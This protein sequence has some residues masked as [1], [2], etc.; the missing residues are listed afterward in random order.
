VHNFSN[1][2]YR[3]LARGVA[4]VLASSEIVR[5]VYARRSVA[6]GEV[7]F[8]RSDIDLG[9]VIRAAEPAWRDKEQ[10]LLL[11]RLYH[12]LKITIPIVGEC[13][14]HDP[15]GLRL[16]S[17]IDPYRASIDRRA[18]LLLHGPP[19]EV[20]VTSVPERECARRL[21]FWIEKFLPPVIRRR[22]KRNLRKIALE[23][24]NAWACASG[25]VS[26]PL[27]T[28][29]EAAI[30]M[31]AAGESL[32]EDSLAQCFHIAAQMHRRLLLPLDHPHTALVQ[33]ML[34]PPALRR[35][36]LVVLAH[37][38]CDLPTEA[39]DPDSL[40]CTPEALDLYVQFVNPFAFARLPEPVRNLG[41]RTPGRI[42]FAD[43]CRRYTDR[44]ML[45]APGFTKM[46]TTEPAQRAAAARFGLEC[47]RAGEF[48]DEP[49]LTP[50]TPPPSL[51]DYY[52]DIYPQLCADMAGVWRGL[53]E[54]GPVSPRF[55]VRSVY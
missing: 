46:D 12:W 32:P 35:R 4:S 14:V 10:L 40:I 11:A 34:L 30:S 48:R 43:C 15:Q 2:A 7:S 21:I 49:D 5:T 37:E 13:T 51:S 18:G 6:A 29:R 28:R 16:W 52:R 1:A 50:T 47:L 17:R 26:E 33:S 27:L 31:A 38:A 42:E 39:F 8:G 44:M 54:I 22:N 3:L 41:I 55:G 23:I 53:E 19:L 9:I 20:A 24:W 45:R 25:L 36:V